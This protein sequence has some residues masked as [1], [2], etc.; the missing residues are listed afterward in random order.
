MTYAATKFKAAGVDGLGEDTITRNH[1]HEHTCTSMDRRTDRL[2][3]TDFGTILMYPLF[4]QEKADIK[5]LFY[6]YV[7]NSLKDQ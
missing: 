2:R 7:F 4:L 3:W 1:T 5:C 6:E